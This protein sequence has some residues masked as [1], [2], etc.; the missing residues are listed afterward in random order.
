M[1][2]VLNVGNTNVQYGL[3]SNGGFDSIQSCPVSDFTTDLI[4]ADTAVACAS[5]VPDFNALLLPF[6]PFF[7]TDQVD[8][9]VDFFGVESSTIGPDRLANAVAL[10]QGALPAIC[11]D[12]GTAL[13]FEMVNADRQFIGGAI[14]PGRA[15]MR[16]ALNDHTAKLPLVPFR[17][18]LPTIGKTTIDAITVGVDRG[19]IG[20]VKEIL[21]SLSEG[22]ECRVIAVGG[23]APFLCSRIPELIAGGVEFTLRGI[24]AAWKR[25]Q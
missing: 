16:K 9:D 20:T 24:V 18:S 2:F 21:S 23:D 8:L 12:C 14:A 25:N 6:K 15:L 13:T 11:V 7:I 3:F 19:I 1:L 4:P 17:E 5:V 22:E 10:A